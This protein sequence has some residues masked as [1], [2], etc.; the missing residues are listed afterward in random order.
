M[1][2]LLL[3]SFLTLFTVQAFATGDCKTKI[4]PSSEELKVIVVGDFQIGMTILVVRGYKTPS[5]KAFI[6]ETADFTVI[7]KIGTYVSMREV[8]GTPALALS[9]DPNSD[10]A[11]LSISDEAILKKLTPSE[12]ASL[13]N[14]TC[15]I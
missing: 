5:R 10:D 4:G 15:N 13:S 2:K 11:S 9:M 7:N 3:V 6:R 1:S 12:V 8:N 14:L